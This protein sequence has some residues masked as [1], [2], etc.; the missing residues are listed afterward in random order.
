M[1]NT[2]QTPQGKQRWAL[3]HPTCSVMALCEAL[4]VRATQYA[5]VCSCPQAIMCVFV[6]GLNPINFFPSYLKLSFPLILSKKNTQLF[7]LH[8]RHTITRLVLTVCVRLQIDWRASHCRLPPPTHTPTPTHTH[9]HTHTN[10]GL[11]ARCDAR[12]VLNLGGSQITDECQLLHPSC[13]LPIRSWT[14][15]GHML[16]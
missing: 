8:C 9:T 10:R 16:A 14:V 7:P 6:L 15:D 3:K 1:H 2:Q 4:L 5:H 12:N 11:S 13:Y